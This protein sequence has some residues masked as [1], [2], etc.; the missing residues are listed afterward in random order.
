MV[1]EALK[2]NG[3]V[4]FVDSLLTQESTATNH[5]ALH[6]QGYSERKLNDGRTYR[7]VKIFYQSDRLEAS[8]QSLG[9]TGKIDRT[10]NYFLYGLVYDSKLT[11]IHARL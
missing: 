1:G 3:K 5:S 6:E 7:I 9:W 4:F 2:P 11:Q 10:A 8:L